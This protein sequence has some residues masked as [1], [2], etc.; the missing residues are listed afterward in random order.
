MNSLGISKAARVGRKPG[1]GDGVWL[2]LRSQH[3]YV[4]FLEERQHSF[5]LNGAVR[6]PYADLRAEQVRHHLAL[7]FD[8]DWVKALS[9][10]VLGCIRTEVVRLLEHPLRVSLKA[11]ANKLYGADHYQPMLRKLSDDLPPGAYVVTNQI[12]DSYII[13]RKEDMSNQNV[14]NFAQCAAAAPEEILE[15]KTYILGRNVAHLSGDSLVALHSQL[16]DKRNHLTDTGLDSTKY[17]AAQIKQI[18][19]ALVVI[20]RKLNKIK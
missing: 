7:F 9:N 2:W 4:Q 18:D 6:K 20:K 13:E 16:E 11:Y 1:I 10:A 14:G 5:M 17:V 8:A 3:D 19:Q 15:H 12:Q